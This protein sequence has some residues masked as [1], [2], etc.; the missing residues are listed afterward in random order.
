MTRALL[1]M[2]MVLPLRLNFVLKARQNY[3][4]GSS[5]HDRV[6]AGIQTPPLWANTP[7]SSPYTAISCLLYMTARVSWKCSLVPAIFTGLLNIHSTRNE[8]NPIS[9]LLKSM[10]KE[11]FKPVGCTF[12]NKEKH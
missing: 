4:K 10:F 8:K 5:T 1:L 12:E 9:V 6:Q 2:S 7:C 3:A 11:L